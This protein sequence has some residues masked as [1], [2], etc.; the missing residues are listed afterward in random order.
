MIVDIS[1]CDKRG[2]KNN[3]QR[4]NKSPKDCALADALQS[5]NDVLE[6]CHSYKVADG[7][8][9]LVI[10]LLNKADKVIEDIG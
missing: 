6:I 4:C 10:K 3:I 7:A 5:L 8:P 1:Y 9:D 2:C